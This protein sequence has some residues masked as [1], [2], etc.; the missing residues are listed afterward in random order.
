MARLTIRVRTSVTFLIS[1]PNSV[2]GSLTFLGRTRCLSLATASW[3]MVTPS[4][5]RFP[6]L[7]AGHIEPGFL[8]DGVSLLEYGLLRGFAQTFELQFARVGETEVNHEVTQYGQ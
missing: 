1:R 3:I 6:F 8:K 5:V 7:I 2:S 4:G